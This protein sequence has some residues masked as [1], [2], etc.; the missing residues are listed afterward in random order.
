MKSEKGISLMKLIIIIVIVIGIIIYIVTYKDGHKLT[1]GEKEVYLNL[2]NLITQAT[3]ATDDNPEN[4]VSTFSNEDYDVISQMI[5]KEDG[6]NIFSLLRDQGWVMSAYDS[7][8]ALIER[9]YTVEQTKEYEV[10]YLY[11][12]TNVA[13]L[14]VRHIGNDYYLFEYEFI[15]FNEYIPNS[16]VLKLQ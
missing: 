1:A 10:T 5:K 6:S 15:S 13:V 7:Y 4:R 12:G 16:V 14:Y 2:R 3:L 9:G 8:D 11:D